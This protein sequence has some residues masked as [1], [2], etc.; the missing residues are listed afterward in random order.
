MTFKFPTCLDYFQKYTYKKMKKQHFSFDVNNLFIYFISLL[1]MSFFC[2]ISLLNCFIVG[3]LLQFIFLPIFYFHYFYC[4]LC[5]YRVPLYSEIYFEF[6]LY[7][8][9]FISVIILLV[10]M[11]IRHVRFSKLT[12]SL[13]LQCPTLPT[14]FLKI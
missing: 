5:E 12:Q 4:E 13:Q 1:K 3:F 2:M 14:I 11:L 10:H 9:K 8:L 7:T 6:I